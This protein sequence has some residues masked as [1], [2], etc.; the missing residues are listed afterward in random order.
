MKVCQTCVVY[1]LYDDPTGY[2]IDP[3]TADARHQTATERLPELIK[4]YGSLKH[5]AWEESFNCD[6]CNSEQS[7]LH[8][9]V[10]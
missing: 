6:A 8:T 1:A 7:G 2:D 3:E 10:G 9:V 5:E 4:G